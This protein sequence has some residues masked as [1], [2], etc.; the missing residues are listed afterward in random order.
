MSKYRDIRREAGAQDDQQ[1]FP[2]ITTLREDCYQNENNE[3]KVEI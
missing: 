1:Y 3:V 2:F